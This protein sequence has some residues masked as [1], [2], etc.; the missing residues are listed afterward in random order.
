MT[1]IYD[2]LPID[3]CGI[4]K[5]GVDVARH[6]RLAWILQLE[7]RAAEDKAVVA[8]RHGL[9]DFPLNRQTVFDDCQHHRLTR[10][11]SCRNLLH[12]FLSLAMARP[13]G[14]HQLRS[15]VKVKFCW[16]I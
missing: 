5:V 1:L 2:L 6:K 12:S 9:D 13:G 14:Y 11:P 8:A 7:A 4:A 10:L 15:Y 16:P 3:C